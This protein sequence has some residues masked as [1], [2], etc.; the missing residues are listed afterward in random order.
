MNEATGET[1]HSRVQT[2]QNYEW[3]RMIKNYFIY[4]V[5]VYGR[6][7]EKLNFGDLMTELFMILY[8]IDQQY[9][10]TYITEKRT[11]EWLIFCRPSPTKPWGYRKLSNLYDFW[12]RFFLMLHWNRT[13]CIPKISSPMRIKFLGHLWTYL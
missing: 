5:W 9:I 6:W 3:F 11:K 1:H 12:F 10:H 2:V 7:T 13:F 8:I 4:I